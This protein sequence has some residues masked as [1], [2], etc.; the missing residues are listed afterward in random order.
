VACVHHAR[1]RAHLLWRLRKLGKRERDE[2]G[3][4]PVNEDDEETVAGSPCCYGS[5]DR[6]LSPVIAS[7]AKQS[8]ARHNGWMDCFV[9]ALLA[10]TK[11]L[12]AQKRSCPGQ[13]RA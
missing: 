6:S 1:F 5:G 3:K 7:E 12:R 13:A 8:I 10:M 9:A 11:G 2:S 4:H